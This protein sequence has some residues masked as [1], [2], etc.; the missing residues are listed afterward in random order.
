M[1]RL[2]DQLS[3]PG[4][5]RGQGRDQFGVAAAGADGWS[6]PVPQ[7]PAKAG[8]LSSFGKIREPTGASLSMGPSGAFANRAAKAKEAARPAA[9]SNP[10]AILSAGGDAAPERPKLVLAPRT[11]PV[12]GSAEEEEKPEEEEAAE[13]EEDDGAIDP[14]AISMSRA[15]GERKAGNS[16]KEVRSFLLV[17]ATCPC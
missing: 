16:V 9:P 8:D 15:E 1:P 3:R 14:N 5:R 6:A 13:E 17:A 11:K 4:S 12:D 7:R 10:F 2:Q